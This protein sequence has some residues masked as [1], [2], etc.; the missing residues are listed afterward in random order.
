MD[1]MLTVGFALVITSD[2]VL[3]DSFIGDPNLDGGTPN[4]DGYLLAFGHIVEIDEVAAQKSL[5][6][7]RQYLTQRRLQ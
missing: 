3:G 1:L 6:K 4:L 5:G 7:T 2:V